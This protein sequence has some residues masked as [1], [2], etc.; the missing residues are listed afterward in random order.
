MSD[1]AST[2]VKFFGPLSKFKARTA[3]T[4]FGY[5]AEFEQNNGVR[6]E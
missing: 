1:I 2:T 3:G 4:F 5:R 6:A